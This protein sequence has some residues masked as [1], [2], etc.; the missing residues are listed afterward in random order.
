M[1]TLLCAHCD[2]LATIR[3]EG[4]RLLR[5]QR[6]NKATEADRELLTVTHKRQLILENSP[7]AMNRKLDNGTW[8]HASETTEWRDG[9]GYD[10]DGERTGRWVTEITLNAETKAGREYV[11]CGRP[12]STLAEAK[13][14]M[15]ALPADFDIEETDDWYY[16]RNVYG[17]RA[18]VEDGD[19]EAQVEREREGYPR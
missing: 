18:Y 2:E 12:F 11:Y 15:E 9:S 13:A 4:D 1:R 14:R 8:V 19:E 5:L 3:E 16:E 6:L 17:S 10:E 7:C